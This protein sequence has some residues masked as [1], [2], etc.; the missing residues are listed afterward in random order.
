MSSKF[1]SLPSTGSEASSSQRLELVRAERSSEKSSADELDRLCINT[2]RFLSVDAVEQAHSGHPGLPLGAAPMAYVLWDRLLRHNPRNP[3]WFNRDRFVLSG[4]H[5]SM[6]LYSLL[7]LTGYDLSLGE[8]QRFRQWDSK[9]PGHPEAGVTPGVEVTTGPLGQGFGMGVGMALAEAHL[10]TCFNRPGF[11]IVDHYTYAIVTDGDLMEGVSAEA[12]SLAGTLKLGKLIYFY[13]NNHISLEGPTDLAFTEDVCQRF[14]SYGWQVLNLADG[15]DLDAID[16]AIRLARTEKDHPSLLVVRNH[17]GYGSP[18]QDTA[19]AHGEPLGPEATRETKQKLGWPTAPAFYIPEEARAH[20]RQAIERGAQLE[21]QWKDLFEN[22]RH[23]HPEEAAELDR[24]IRGELPADWAADLPRFKPDPAGLATR[25]A[26]ATVMNA[27]AKRLPE[28]IGGSA[29]LNP[30]TKTVLVGYGDFGFGHGG[31]RNIHFGVREHAMGTIVNGM[32]MHS[33]VIPYGATFFVFTDYMRPALRIAALMESRS[34]FV[35]THDSIGLGEDGPTHQPVEQL[36]SLRAMPNLTLL[37]PADANETAVAWRVAIER[38]GPVCLVL[39]RQN[40][41]I[42]D[43]DAYP[44]R[45]GVARGAYILVREQAHADVILIA[46]GSEVQLALRARD[47]LAEHRIAARVVSMPS[48]ELF[49]EQPLEYREQVLPK[50]VPKLAIEAGATLG[51]Y[52]YVGDKGAV[53]GVDRFGA[54]APGKVV[55]ENLGLN[56]D[57]VVQHA[58]QLAGR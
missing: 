48:W 30:S 39:T 54:S 4:G 50:D 15:T 10:A 53:I 27:I 11:P 17:I 23:Q 41:P 16:A 13:D 37:R 34:I 7:H 49:E 44:L 40:L 14:R 38:R 36:M 51:W 8:I 57:N 12:A 43:P 25:S 32:A 58:L 45:D 56:V 3:H 18:K 42:L 29:D 21:S 19:E 55:M 6:L 46:S 26:S 5:G 35:F 24:M 47:R 31:G 33:G 1:D 2:I 28:F 20:F 52:K 9:A 22:Y